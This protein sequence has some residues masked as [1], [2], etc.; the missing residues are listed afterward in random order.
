MVTGSSGAAG[1]RKVSL[2][3][4]RCDRPIGTA[5]LVEPDATSA[6]LL[7]QVGLSSPIPLLRLMMAQSNCFQVVDR[8]A[9]MGTIEKED[10]LARSGM[11]R[12]GS[13]TARGRL[14]TVQYLLTPN[15]VF[16]NPNAGGAE[17]GAAIGGLFGP[18]GVVAGA[19]AGSIRL[20]Q[21]QAALFLTD[22]QSGV[23][24]AVAE[25]A[26]EVKDFGGMVGIGG[27]GGGLAGI[28]GVAGYGNTAEGKLIAAALMDA[29]NKLVEHVSVSRPN[30][31]DRQMRAVATPKDVA[32]VRG[33][34][35]ELQT[36]GYYRSGIDGIYGPG[37]ATAIRHYQKDNGLLEDGQPTPQL[38]DHLR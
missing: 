25:G 19:L 14:V 16:S 1:A 8:G 26:A 11:L 4:A 22:A 34:Q 18:V 5:A 33:I 17:L 36:R 29:H 28:G 37:T 6:Q 23:Q 21:A 15:V 30:L 12:Q 9:A 7:T 10:A 35:V 24:T 13:T 20:Q 27:W 2:E 38:L 32:L 3:L 31:P